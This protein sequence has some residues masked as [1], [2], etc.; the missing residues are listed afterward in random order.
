MVQGAA[1][2]MQE[3]I[4]ALRRDIDKHGKAKV[5]RGQHALLAAKVK[6]PLPPPSRAVFL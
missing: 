2:Y 3:R 6:P 1:M 4:E 5:K